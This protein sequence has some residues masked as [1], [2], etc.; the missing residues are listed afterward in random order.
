MLLTNGV[1]AAGTSESEQIQAF[2]P[3]QDVIDYFAEAEQD[4]SFGG[5]YYNESGPLIINLVDGGSPNF[6]PSAASFTNVENVDVEYD[7]VAYSLSTLESIKDFLSR[8][9]RNIR[10]FPWMQMKQQTR[11]TSLWLIIIALQLRL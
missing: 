9:W 5:L 7:V 8:I 10:S 4:A 11:W 1:L 2:S 6:A 3:E